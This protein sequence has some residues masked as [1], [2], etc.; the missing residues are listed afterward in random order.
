MKIN[1]KIIFIVS[2]IIIIFI[3]SYIR[4]TYPKTISILGAQGWRYAVA[5]TYLPLS[6]VLGFSKNTIAPAV[7]LWLETYPNANTKQAAFI[8]NTMEYGSCPAT[9]PFNCILCNITSDSF[10][11][12]PTTCSVC[13]NC[14]IPP[15][16]PLSGLQQFVHTAMS[17]GVPLAGLTMMALG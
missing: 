7:T 6:S 4:S 17:Y 16:T 10:T 11:T 8:V 3:F 12:R 13:N 15:P 9:A 1:G 2:L 5:S 14:N